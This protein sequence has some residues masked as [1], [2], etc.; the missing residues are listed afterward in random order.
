MSRFAKIGFLRENL[1][2]TCKASEIRALW[3]GR[4][5]AWEL[6]HLDKILPQRDGEQDIQR[7]KTQTLGKK[8]PERRRAGRGSECAP[9][10]ISHRCGHL[11]EALCSG[12]ESLGRCGGCETLVSALRSPARRRRVPPAFE[13]LV[14]DSWATLP[15]ASGKTACWRAQLHLG[16]LKTGCTGYRIRM[17]PKEEV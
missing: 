8:Y 4:D 7:H 6:F 13:L 17:K 12:L 11:P 1:G 2:R 14:Q 3:D 5:G 15:A 16:E 9:N 10:T